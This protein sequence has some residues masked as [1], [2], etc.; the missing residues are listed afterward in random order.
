[1]YYIKKRLE[2]SACHSL[3]LSYDSK[4]SNL[5]GHNWIITVYCKAAQL[6]ADGMVCDFT[7]VKQLIN[8]K[9]D[10]KNLNDEFDFNPTAENL[11]RWVVDTIPECYRADVQESEN[12]IATYIEE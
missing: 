12:N 4:C 2:A 6:N 10:H 1:M 3:R 8:N 11:A 5:H 7:H 9:I